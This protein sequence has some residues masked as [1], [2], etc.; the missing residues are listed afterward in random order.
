MQKVC[1]DSAARISIKFSDSDSDSH[2]TKYASTSPASKTLLRKYTFVGGQIDG[3]HFSP[4]LFTCEWNVAAEVCLGSWLHESEDKTVTGCFNTRSMEE[5]NLSK[6]R[7]AKVWPEHH[8]WAGIWLI[9]GEG[10]K[11]SIHSH[12]LWGGGCQ[13]LIK[14]YVYICGI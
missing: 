10:Q 14:T 11:I 5:L 9:S 4:N 3:Y 1:R 7:K 2:E 12:F 8:V 13:I 6:T